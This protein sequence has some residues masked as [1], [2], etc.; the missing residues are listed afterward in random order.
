MALELAYG[1]EA[2]SLQVGSVTDARI[3]H[4]I[5]GVAQ[6]DT[7]MGEPVGWDDAV[8]TAD[9]PMKG[10]TRFSSSIEQDESGNVIYKSGRAMDL[11]SFGPVLVNVSA[12][13]NAGD[14]AY[15]VF[16]DQTFTKTAG[17]GT[18]TAAVGYF[19]TTTAGAGTA[20]LFVQR[21]V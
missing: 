8:I 1:L 5:T 17:A 11:V 12:A 10:V 7:G 14:A 16:A 9:V 15:A 4:T 18:T 6:A 20:V 2:D 21:G 19:E 3:T 13:V